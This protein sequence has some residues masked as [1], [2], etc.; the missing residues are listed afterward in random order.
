VS[1]QLPEVLASGSCVRPSDIDR[2]G[3]PDLF[4]GGR[5]VPGNYPQAPESNIL[6]NDGKGNFTIDATVSEPVKHLGMVTDAVWVDLNNDSYDDLVVV[7]EW[8][9]AKVLINEEGKLKDRSSGYV[10]ANTEGLWNCIQASDFDGDGDLDFVAGN[11]GTNHQMKSANDKPVSLYYSDYDNNGSIDPI[12]DYFVKDA[13]Y[14]YPTRD[15]LME[16]LPGIRK[17]FKDY[18]SYSI[19]QLK[20]VLTE[21]Q[22][23]NSKVLK[24]YQLKSCFIR[25]D[26]GRLSFIPLSNEFQVAPIFSIVDMDV[27]GDGK[28]DIVTGGN[29]TGTRSRTGQLSGNCGIIGINDGHGQFNPMKQA[30]SGLALTGDVRHIL[31]LNE[32]L[33]I[34]VNNQ[35]VSVYQKQN[36]MK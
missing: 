26:S 3:D 28:I 33:V 13:S 29:L 34:G 36:L 20:D 17:K 2:D 22:L 15:E 9:P 14:P 16:Q 27:D 24:A 8:M 30:N 19:A 32:F 1:R 12:I 11:I 18:K 7:G 6:I 25:N 31:E 35:K 21:D 10:P 23:K 5:I 4:V